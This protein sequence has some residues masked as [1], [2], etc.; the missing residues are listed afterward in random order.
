MSPSIPGR[1]QTV[2]RKSLFVLL[3]AALL[4]CMAT[5][6]GVQALPIGEQRGDFLWVK[7]VAGDFQ[8]VVDDIKDAVASLNFP[9]GSIKD[10]QKSFGARI[11]QLGQGKLPFQQYQIIEFCNVQLALKALSA[12]LRMGIFMPCRVVVFSPP[13]GGLV[14]I[15]TVNPAFMTKT[16]DNPN[17]AVIAKE[18]E[19]VIRAV[20][21][22]V[23]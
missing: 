23:E 14:T 5:W 18:V 15:M 20:F 17:L 19:G 12:D 22:V 1:V 6:N 7:T 3:L 11:K 4:G 16:L 2:G 21:L 10:Y 8:Q 9:V 13:G